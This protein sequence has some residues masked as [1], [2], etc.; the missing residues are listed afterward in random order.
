MSESEWESLCDG[1]GQCCL[2][3]LEDEDT[4]DIAITRAACRLL[5]I[6]TCRCSN[7]AGRASFVPDCVKLDAASVKDLRWL[8]ET[9]AYRLIGA[10]RDLYWWH[11]LVSGTQET[12]H[13]AGASVRNFAVSENGVSETRLLRLIFGWIRTSKKR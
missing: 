2:L 6:G 1:C 4:G 13:E 11:P 5:D 12:V 8:P 9:C 10:G 3:K 7:Y